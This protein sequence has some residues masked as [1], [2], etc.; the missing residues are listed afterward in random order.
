MTRAEKQATID[1]LKDTFASNDYFYFTDT[2][3]LNVEDIVS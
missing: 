2:T 1:N 3:G